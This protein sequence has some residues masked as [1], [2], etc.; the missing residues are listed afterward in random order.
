MKKKALTLAVLALFSAIFLYAMVCSVLS[1]QASTDIQVVN[2]ESGAV[3]SQVNVQ[4]TIDTPSGSFLIFFGDQPVI[5]SN[6]SENAVNSDFPVPNLPVG[7][8]NITLRD[9]TSDGSA[10]RSFTII[11]TGI[12]AIPWSTLSIMGVSL[13]IAIINSGLN[14]ALISRFVGW[15]EYRSMQKEMSE[16][17]SQ[18]MAAMRAND[19]KQLEKL[20]KK[21]SQIMNMQ[22][23]MVKPQL[24]LFGLSFVYIFLFPILTGYFP[25]PVVNVPGFGIQPFFIWYLLCSFFFGTLASRIWGILPME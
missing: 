22:K 10:T 7:K 9:A 21:E 15:N 20:K 3:G 25:N 14:R 1:Q 2:P 16:W 5:N 12:S 8:Y 17:R 13:S 4:G 6:A 18:Q 24:L 11:S 23:K 19:K